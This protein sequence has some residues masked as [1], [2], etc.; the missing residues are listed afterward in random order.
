MVSG[1]HFRN[2]QGALSGD[3]SATALNAVACEVH[4]Q[5]VA[6]TGNHFEGVSVAVGIGSGGTTQSILIDGNVGIVA[7]FATVW[8]GQFPV[9]TRSIKI[10]NNLVAVVP[11]G[12]PGPCTAS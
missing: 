12:A 1:N 6:L 4:A 11:Y 10:S 3:A 7:T 8:S 9:T 2:T 5:N